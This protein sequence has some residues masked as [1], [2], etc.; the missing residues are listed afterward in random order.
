VVVTASAALLDRA[1]E[2]P[3]VALLVAAGLEPVRCRKGMRVLPDATFADHPRLDVVIVPGG[4]GVLL[5]SAN[6]ELQDWL[7]RVGG[8][9]SWVASVCTGALLL[10]SSGLRATQRYIQYDPAP[11]YQADV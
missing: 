1:G 10:H 5:A 2:P 3:D 11:P 4:D 9:A 7:V 6:Q 8:E